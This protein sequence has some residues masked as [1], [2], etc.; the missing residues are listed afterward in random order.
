MQ[1][2]FKKEY[3][4]LETPGTDAFAITP[5]ADLLP[6]ATRALYVGGAGDLEVMMVSYENANTVVTFKNVPAGSLLPIR[7]QAVLTGTT[8]TDIVGIY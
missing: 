4:T 2:R 3:T 5:S 8:A 1:D 7:V 6:W